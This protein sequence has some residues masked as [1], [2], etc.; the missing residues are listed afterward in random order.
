MRPLQFGLWRAGFSTEVWSYF[1]LRGPAAHHSARLARHL[2]RCSARLPE[3]GPVR[4]H[5]VGHSLGTVVA[6]AALLETIPPRFGRL[7]LMAPPNRGAP[8]AAWF[9]TTVGRF[10]PAV[11]DLAAHRDSFIHNLAP[12]DSVDF[13][14]L[15]ARF[16]EFIPLDTT[17]LPGQRDYRAL[18]H[19]HASILFSPGAVRAVASFLRHGAFDPPAIQVTSSSPS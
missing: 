11:A 13:A 19:T 15:A 7:V 9:R 2:E 5:L 1:S 6:R 14:V 12:P 4:L 18:P 17:P 16:D 3:H 10:V 8:L